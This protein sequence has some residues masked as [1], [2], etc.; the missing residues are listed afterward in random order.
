MLSLAAPPLFS[1]PGLPWGSV[2]GL[3]SL[4]PAIS[5]SLPPQGPC[6]TEPLQRQLEVPATA[7]PSAASE[8]GHHDSIPVAP[9]GQLRVPLAEASPAGPGPVGASAALAR[10][11]RSC[12]RPL[13]SSPSHPLRS[14]PR[15]SAWTALKRS[16]ARERRFGSGP[17]APCQCAR[18]S[19][20]LS[21]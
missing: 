21:L 12:A 5:C 2:S 10:T 17:P 6:G 11:T 15:A 16:R 13:G 9:P 20:S 18:E 4:W 8:R 7:T 3:H 14:L 1:W 19:R